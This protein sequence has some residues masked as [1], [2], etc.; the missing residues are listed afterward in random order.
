MGENDALVVGLTA[1]NC[2]WKKEYSK[3]KEERGA[4][5]A[6]ESAGL[7]GHTLSAREKNRFFLLK[8]IRGC[9]AN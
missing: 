6:V 9:G 5:G 3:D 8:N 7:T 2:V 4:W 1:C